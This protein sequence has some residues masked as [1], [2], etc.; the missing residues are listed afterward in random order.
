MRNQDRALGREAATAFLR[1]ALAVTFLSSVADRFGLWGPPLT[2][3]VAW[4]SF[5]TFTDYAARLNPW[6]PPLF[7]P[8]LAW[9]V[10][11]VE[12]SLAVALLAGYWTRFAA[13]ASGCLLLVHALEMAVFIGAKPALDASIFVAASGAFVLASVSPDRWSVD[14]RRIRLRRWLAEGIG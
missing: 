12:V 10:T 7:A 11:T 4:G 13:L 1:A 5:P 6:S 8:T 9:T 3:G 14:D 2:P